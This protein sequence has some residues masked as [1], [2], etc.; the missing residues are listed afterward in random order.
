MSKSAPDDSRGDKEL[1]RQS[2][3][4]RDSRVEIQCFPSSA[5]LRAALAFVPEVARW[6][7]KMMAVLRGAAFPNYER[8]L[9]DVG[10]KI[11]LTLVIGFIFRK[12]EFKSWKDKAVKHQVCRALLD[13]FFSLGLVKWW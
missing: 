5:P 11:L 1:G 13:I 4:N 2:W 6:Y 9:S 8:E 7:G 10:N 12:L 3:A